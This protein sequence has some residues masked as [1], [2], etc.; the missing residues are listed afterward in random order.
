[1]YIQS[2]VCMVIAS[3]KLLLLTSILLW[4]VW[5]RMEFYD[6]G[7]ETF[8]LRI[9][10][11]FKDCHC[12]HIYIYIY[13]SVCVHLCMITQIDVFYVFIHAL[14][15]LISLRWKSMMCA[16]FGDSQCGMWLVMQWNEAKP[17]QLLGKFSVIL[18]AI[19][20]YNFVLKII[21]L[22]KCFEEKVDKLIQNCWW[23]FTLNRAQWNTSSGRYKRDRDED[24]KRAM[25]IWYNR[26]DS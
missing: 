17:I 5:N 3:K 4:L 9:F 8:V 20:N 12:Y 16:V 24:D 26:D 11:L 13:M 15:S 2:F 18:M 14:P 25:E 23:D 7:K 1:M 19:K 6:Y 10:L 21:K 22:I